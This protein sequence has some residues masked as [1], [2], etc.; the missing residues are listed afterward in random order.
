ML[1][2]GFATV[3]ATLDIVAIVAGVFMTGEP[4]MRAVHGGGADWMD[5]LETGLF[6]ALLFVF[7]SIIRNEYVI[8]KYLSPQGQFG[9]F[10]SLW[11][12][13]LVTCLAFAFLTKTTAH[14]SRGTIILFYFV[15][16]WNILALRWLLARLVRTGAEAG[17]ISSR[18][19]FIVGFERDV[20]TFLERHED[21]PA[22]MRIVAA[23]VL[24]GMET[25]SD[26]LA[27]AAASARMVRPDDVYI[28]VPWSH[29]A[30]IDSCVDVFLRVPA[31][32][33]LG[34]EKV[35]DRFL[36]ARISKVGVISSLH[37][38]R[39]PLSASDV[40]LKRL[41]DIIGALGG[42][43]LLS[44][45]FLIGALAIRLESKGPAFFLQRRYGFN[46]EPFRIVKFRS[47]RTMEEGSAVVQ[48]TK[49]DARITRV[50]RFMRRTNIDELPQLLNVLSGDMSLV[51]P[52]PHPQVLDQKYAQVIAYY[53]RRHNV[54]PGITGWAQ[55]NGYRGETETEDKMRGRIEYDLHYIDNWSMWL[56]LR[57][58]WLTIF[59]RKA[60]N[61]AG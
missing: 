9:R 61:N 12:L 23:S 38:V 11:N 48:A 2:G 60:Y 58:I 41:V 44:P 16:G 19:A 17:V 47:M 53:A 20:E 18:R 4:Y 22:E 7:G 40:A 29:S 24:R 30:V 13:V 3:A 57:I 35:L 27:L 28:L 31:S 46:Q 51:G 21:D 39:Q 36:D 8:P 25:L 10:F 5:Y 56:D 42:L 45:V 33:H 59:S 55:V 15:G 34:P 1:R 6:I 43:I 26:D 52:R 50:G 37:I 32:I 49:G 54:K 14:F